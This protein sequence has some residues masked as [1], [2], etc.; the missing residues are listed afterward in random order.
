MIKKI[1]NFICKIFNIKQ[2]ACSEEPLE[3]KEE[4]V[5]RKMDKINRKYKKEIE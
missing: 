3:L 5:H 2:C 1:K 4:I